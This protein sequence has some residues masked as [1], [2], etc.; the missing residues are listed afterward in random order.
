MSMSAF[1]FAKADKIF[2]CP[3]FFE[4]VSRSIRKSFASGN[5]CAAISSIFW[6]PMPKPARYGEPQF[7]HSFG[8][9]I[10]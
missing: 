9:G 8:M 7:G 1:P 3:P 6:V 2:S 5:I 4:V 10:W